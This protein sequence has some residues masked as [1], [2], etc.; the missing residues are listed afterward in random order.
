MINI[1]ILVNCWYVRIII[2]VRVKILVLVFIIKEL[3]IWYILF[4]IF[5]KFV[6]VFGI[7]IFKICL[8]KVKM[9]LMWKV[10]VL[11]ISFFFFSILLEIVVMLVG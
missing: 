11:I 5:K 8:K 4:E 3:N 7:R 2:L 1:C 10:M 9:I 6:K